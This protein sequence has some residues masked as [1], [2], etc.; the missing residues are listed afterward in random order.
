MASNRVLLALIGLLAFVV[1]PVQLVTTFLLGLLANLTFGLVLIVL[2]IPWMLLLGPMLLLSRLSGRSALVRSAIG[3]VFLPWALVANTYSCLIPSMGE[4]DSRV[5]KLLLCQFWPYTWEFWL[6]S[7]GQLYTQAT[8][9][10]VRDFRL[11]APKI[12]RGDVLSQTVFDE[13]EDMQ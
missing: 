6:F 11:I 1:L 8:P 3:F 9:N 4:M 7:K 5:T 2:S 10:G 13:L 12:L